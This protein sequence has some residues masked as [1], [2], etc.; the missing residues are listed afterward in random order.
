M[1]KTI[2]KSPTA[3][4]YVNRTLSEIFRLKTGTR[5]SCPLSPSLFALAIEPLAQKIRQTEEVSGMNI[6]KDKYK[7]SL[8]A[9]DLVLFIKLIL[10]HLF[11]SNGNHSRFLQNIRL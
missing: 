11:Q 2:Y 1:I 9:D 7:L 3:Q 4:V 5:H 8:F 6:D 10:K